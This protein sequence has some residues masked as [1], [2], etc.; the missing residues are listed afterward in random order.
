MTH[1]SFRLLLVLVLVPAVLLGSSASA[2]GSESRKKNKSSAALEYV[3]P[4]LKEFLHADSLEFLS[5]GRVTM[6]FD[7]N[8]K[9]TDHDDLFSRKIDTDFRSPFRWSVLRE[10]RRWHRYRRGRRARDLRGIRIS[11]QGLAVLNCWFK[12][13]SSSTSSTGTWGPSAGVTP[14][15]LFFRRRMGAPWAV[16]SGHSV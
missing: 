1:G 4:R 15:L 6:T 13:L 3:R 7:F 12:D 10:E 5:D 8:K 14:W 9:N 16:I 11:N 2:E